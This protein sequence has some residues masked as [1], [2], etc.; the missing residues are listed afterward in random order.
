MKHPVLCLWIAAM[1]AGCA[2][3][4]GQ[5]TQWTRLHSGEPTPPVAA[6]TNHSR[7]PDSA[8]P[9]GGVS[10]P[11]EASKSSGVLPA[12]GVPGWSGGKWLRLS[13][14]ARS[15]LGATPRLIANGSGTAF[16]IETALGTVILTPATRVA[17]F[18]GVTFWL[19]FAPVWSEG[20][21]LVHELDLNK[22][23]R[24]LLTQLPGG[25]PRRGKVVIDP[26]HGGGNL[27]TRS[28]LP[29]LLE[30][31]L[32]LDW[33]LRLEPLLQRQ[34]WEVVLTR[35][36]DRD[37]SLAERVQ[38]ADQCGADLFLSLHFNSAFPQTEQAGLETFCLTPVGLPST[39]TRNYEDDVTRVFPNNAHDEENLRY[40]VRLHRALLQ[41]GGMADRSV[42]RARFMGVLRSQQRPA[43]LLEAGY[44]SNPE[45]AGR[46][47]TP[48]YRQ[49][50]AEAVASGLATPPTLAG[51]AAGHRQQTESDE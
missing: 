5:R 25:L 16:S 13:D 46:A 6:S 24:P 27:G 35:R 14:W 11:G 23:V 3:R 51:T 15:S 37:L 30:K 7:A 29:G 18:E 39:L 47:A 33:A 48:A 42:R 8:R 22:N 41:G 17:V 12:P 10:V 40:A 21:C 36:D 38:V 9:L 45:E 26:G 32:T 34:G 19:G 44:L 4:G 50:L 31:D 20:D 28:V 2:S 43:V 49:R 1:V